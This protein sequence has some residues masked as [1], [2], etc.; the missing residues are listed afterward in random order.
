MRSRVQ[1]Y[2]A[3]RANVVGCNEF[4]TTESQCPRAVMQA[5]AAMA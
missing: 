5:E 4:V 3:G 2:G 1:C